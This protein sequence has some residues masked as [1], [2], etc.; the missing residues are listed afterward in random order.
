MLL[1]ANDNILQLKLHQFLK[2]PN[3]LPLPLHARFACGRV[4]KSVGG[5]ANRV[6][7]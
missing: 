6:F 7:C 1:K 4:N 2:L 5:G 3:C